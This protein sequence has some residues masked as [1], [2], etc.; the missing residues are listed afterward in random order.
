MRSC[1]RLRAVAC[2]RHVRSDINQNEFTGTLPTEIG[3]LKLNAL[4]AHPHLSRARALALGVLMF[5]AR[6]CAPLRARLA[7][8][9]WLTSVLPTELATLTTLTALY[10]PAC[11]CSALAAHHAP[12]PTL[13][14]TPRACT[15]TWGGTTSRAA[16]HPVLVG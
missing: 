14:T 6:E 8:R 16:C 15:A 10:V 7:N 2:S 11:A 1:G 9:N 5:P 4:Y 12:R 3:S 13:P